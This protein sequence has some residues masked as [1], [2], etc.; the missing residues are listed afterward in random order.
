MYRQTAE[1]TTETVLLGSSMHVA[2]KQ[3]PTSVPPEQL[4][5]GTRPR[6]TCSKSH[7]YGSGFHGSPVVQNARSDERSAAG[8]PFGNSARVRVGDSPSIV[9]RSASTSFQR[10]SSGQSGA[11][12]AKTI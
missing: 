3:A 6:P 1:K 8:S 9:T 12:S 2:R 7:A 10:R 11:P 4:T 5:I